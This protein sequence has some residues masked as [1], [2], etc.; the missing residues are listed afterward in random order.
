MR[1]M[2]SSWLPFILS[3]SL[4]WQASR[5]YKASCVFLLLLA[6]ELAPSQGCRTLTSVSRLRQPLP[7]SEDAVHPLQLQSPSWLHSWVQKG[8]KIARLCLVS[9]QGP[10]AYQANVITTTLQKATSTCLWMWPLMGL[11]P[12][13]GMAESE[14]GVRLTHV[15]STLGTHRNHERMLSISEMLESPGCCSCL[16]HREGWHVACM[17][18]LLLC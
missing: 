13:P 2:G 15:Q 1:V 5:T 14:P 16:V 17:S 8:G 3:C 12:P 18:M 7:P 9:N 4:I 10:S 11:S 6:G